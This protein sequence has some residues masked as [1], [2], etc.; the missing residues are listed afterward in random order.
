[1]HPR[2]RRAVSLALSAAVH[3]LLLLEVYSMTIVKPGFPE[4]PPLPVRIIEPPPPKAQAAR[5][6]PAPAPQVASKPPEA[7]KPIEEPPPQQP[8]PE[9]PERKL[10]VPEQQIV[11]P[12]DAGKNEVPPD[13]R[14]LSDRDNRV[15]QQ[16]V[17]KGNPAPGEESPGEKVPPAKPKPAQSRPKPAEQP[18]GGSRRNRE[19]PPQVASLPSID[20][21][22]PNALR[23]AEEGYGSQAEVPEQFAQ[24]DPS[25]RLKPRGAEG[26]LIPSGGPIGTLDFLPDVREGDITLLNTKAEVFAPFVR[27]VAIRVFQNFLI[28]LKREMA[29]SGLPTTEMVEAE[30]VM[31]PHGEMIA[32]NV[33]QRSARIA[34][35]SDRRLQ[36]ACHDG[37][38]DRNPPPGARAKDGKI[39]FVFRTAVEYMPTARGGGYYVFLSAGLL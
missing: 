13:T 37:F 17:K 31:D 39:H 25:R 5:K 28:S 22:M 33:S 30:A 3:A 38:F 11:A 23:L 14:L 12:P 29:G 7:A 36:Q 10:P 8:P 6:P 15:E 18:R 9:Q 2:A 32:F 21:L 26:L 1:M 19:P 34:L 35:A 16:T 20:R 27:R 24:A 4:Q